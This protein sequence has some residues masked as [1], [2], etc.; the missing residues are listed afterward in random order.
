MR[1]IFE[2]ENTEQEKGFSMTNAVHCLV[3]LAKDFDVEEPVARRRGS[4]KVYH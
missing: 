1:C 2:A 3:E 4:H